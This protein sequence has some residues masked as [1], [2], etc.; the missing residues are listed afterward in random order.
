MPVAGNPTGLSAEAVSKTPLFTVMGTADKLMKISNVETFLED[1]DDYNAEYKFDIEEGWT[2]E[3]VC[4]KSYTEER[5]NWLF[6]HTKE[7]ATG[8]NKA[9]NDKGEIVKVVWF[10]V[11][12]QRLTSEP[13]Q[14]GIYIKSSIYNNGRAVSEK[15]YIN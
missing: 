15:S 8:I 5:L 6:K 2:H 13:T 4:E 9:I 7:S 10:S 3:N 14:R 12:G 11:S 1:M